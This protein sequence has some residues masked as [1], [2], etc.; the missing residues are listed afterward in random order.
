MFGKFGLI[1]SFVVV[2]GSVHSLLPFE[3]HT[4]RYFA[5]VLDLQ[6]LFWTVR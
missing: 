3:L 1:A 5:K 4:Q 2:Y 6:N